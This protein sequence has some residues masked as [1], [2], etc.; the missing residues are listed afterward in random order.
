[1]VV[2]VNNFGDQNGLPHSRATE[3]AGLAPALKRGQ[4]IDRFNAGDK[5]VRRGHLLGQGDGRL[6]NGPLLAVSERRLSSTLSK[7]E[8]F[9][10]NR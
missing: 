8:N 4:D 5:D 3:E 10:L 2:E 1:M 6:M 9:S 7:W